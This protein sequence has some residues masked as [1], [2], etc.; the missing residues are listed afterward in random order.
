MP[1]V[2]ELR[3]LYETADRFAR[4]VGELRSE[5]PIPAHNELRYAGHH[6]LQS[7]NDDGVVADEDQ[8]RKAK[9]HCERAMYEAAEAGIMQVLEETAEF[10]RAYNKS[11]FVLEVMPDFRERLLKARSAQKLIIRGR[12][13]RESAEKHAAQY[14]EA[15]RDLSDSLA[16]HFLFLPIPVP[17]SPLATRCRPPAAVRAPAAALNA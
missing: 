7:L 6:L 11:I 13:D 15:F 16:R 9:N 10:R 4:E 3:Q 1:D 2:T 14:M 8:F 17:G 5:V 12:A